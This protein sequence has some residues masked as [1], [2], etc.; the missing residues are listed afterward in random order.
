METKKTPSGAVVEAIAN[1]YGELAQTSCCLSCGGAVGYAEPQPGEHCL[2]MG[3][4]RGQ[5]VFRMAEAVGSTGKVYGLDI[6]E[7][8]LDK[9]R[10][11]A[12]KLGLENVEFVRSE[13]ERIPL[14]DS[15]LN[16]VIS[17][18]TINHANDKRAVWSEIH[19]VLK[20][21]GRFV[22]SDIYA[23]EPVPEEYRNDPEAVAE[24]WAGA[25]LRELYLQTL[26]EVGF[27]HVE[28][29]EESAPYEK[30]KIRVAS[31][32]VGGFRAS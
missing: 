18:C 30:G 26:D 23:I 5:D 8:M 1:R 22:V 24:C 15:S 32:T 10:R 2:D 25:E 13:L 16:L 3:S 7:A 27:V 19:R 14:S 21:G 6:T 11:T 9:G 4:G 12:S 20:P 31:F 29:L 17:N 28:V